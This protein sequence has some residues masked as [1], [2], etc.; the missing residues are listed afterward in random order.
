MIIL[1]FL[2]RIDIGTKI[3]YR[4]ISIDYFNQKQILCH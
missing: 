3:D 4:S 1:P 2:K